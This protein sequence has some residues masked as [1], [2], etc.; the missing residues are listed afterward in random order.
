MFLQH[1][2]TLIP[3]LLWRG[4]NPIWWEFMS[5]KLARL[6]APLLLAVCFAANVA[7]AW[8][9]P[10]AYRWLLLLQVVFYATAVGGLLLD[11]GGRL[12][13]VMSVPMMFVSLNWTTV[14]ALSDASRGRFTA[15][16]KRI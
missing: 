12:P 2:W 5:H 11:R 13:K 3:R 4:G 8:T 16:W 1:P 14:L 7:L 15:A 10:A 6:A 9:G